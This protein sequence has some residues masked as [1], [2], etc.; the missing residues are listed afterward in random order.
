MIY[1]QNE[2]VR[3]PNLLG[4]KVETDPG[5]CPICETEIHFRILGPWLRDQLVCPQCQSIPR[6]RALAVVLEREAPN[7]RSLSIHESSPV[8]RGISKKLANECSGYVASHY[9]PEIPLRESAGFKNVNIEQQW[10]SDESFDVFVALDVM[11][12]VFD[13]VSATKEIFRTI[14]TGGIA[15]MTFPI[16]K[17]QVNAAILRAERLASGIKFLKSAEY[18]GNPVSDSG[19][20][21]TVDYGYD[22]HQELASWS[23]FEVEIARFSS[24]RY[25]ILGEF[26][27]VVV[28]KKL[29]H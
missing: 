4:G 6:E 2:K 17:N 22:I 19:S 11:E 14:R 16:Q 29:E 10:F 25:G 20:L 7:W 12:H 9:F 1:A 21:V 24:A 27:E 18:H 23:G 3:P 15:L 8:S 5:F 26:T 28:L 13:P